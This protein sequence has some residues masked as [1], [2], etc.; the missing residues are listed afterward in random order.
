MSV[1]AS[2]LAIVLFLAFASAG[3]QKIIF[4]PVISKAAG[5]L[6]F[7]KRT[8]RLI[9]LIEVVGAI[10]LLIGLAATGSSPLAVVNEIAAGAL[11]LTVV[12]AVTFHL[13]K[14]DK[15]KYFAPAIALGV[16]A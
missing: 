7:T 3:A 16:L 5:H 10:A 2:L 9:G 15:A 13:R 6:G 4:N 11:I 1:V 14:G 12:V 8:S